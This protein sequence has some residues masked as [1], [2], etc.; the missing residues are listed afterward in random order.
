AC[1]HR[2]PPDDPVRGE[3]LPGD[4]SDRADRLDDRSREVPAVEDGGALAAELFEGAAEVREPQDVSGHEPRAVGPA[5]D[6]PSL[7]RVPEDPVEDPVQV[8]LL[9]G[10]LDPV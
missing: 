4:P 7:V 6:A 2:A 3:I 10:H 9:P 8:G 1:V 5:V